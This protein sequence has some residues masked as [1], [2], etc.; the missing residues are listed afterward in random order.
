MKEERISCLLLWKL[1]QE[2]NHF[3]YLLLL[4]LVQYE[5]QAQTGTGNMYIIINRR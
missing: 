5:W 1:R 3:Q 2:V 4:W